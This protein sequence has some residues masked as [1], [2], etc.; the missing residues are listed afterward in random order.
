M[1]KLIIFC[2]LFCFLTSS[3]SA[4]NDAI[5]R[6]FMEQVENEIFSSVYVSPKLIEIVSEVDLRTLDEGL[7]LDDGEF[8]G[9]EA[10][11]IEEI[12]KQLKGLMV[13]RTDI[14]PMKHYKEVLAKFSNHSANFDLLL[15]VRDEGNNVKIWTETS[16]T[17]TIKELLLLVGGED[18]MIMLS[19]TG[20]IDLKKISRLAGN[21]DIDGIQYLENLDKTEQ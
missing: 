13:L 3:I 18:E 6:Y 5:N 14:E 21:V 4:Q 10:A 17:N 16:S 12:L 9:N 19:L 7:D 1:K 15:S 8:Q 20:N 11:M 2:S